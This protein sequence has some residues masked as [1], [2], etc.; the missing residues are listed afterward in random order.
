MSSG[1][2]S[3][4]LFPRLHPDR[5]AA[6]PEPMTVWS[7]RAFP[8]YPRRE[9]G[10]KI[11]LTST[12]P[13]NLLASSKG[14]VR[15]R[16]SQ[17]Y[18]EGLSLGTG[19]RRGAL[20]GRGVHRCELLYGKKGARGSKKPRWGKGTKYM[21]VVDGQGIPSG[22][23]TDSASPAEVRL[24]EK[25][26]QQI[27]VPKIRTGETKDPAEKS[28]RGQGVRQRPSPLETLETRNQSAFSASPQP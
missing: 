25:I 9:R 16:R 6:V 3:S 24:A 1:G 7:S 17:G 2:R 28:N 10:G 12:P 21:V 26:L 13:L 23:H 19:C 27:K 15:S 11:I 5:R 4:P 20:L 18:V 8:G 14:M 22:S